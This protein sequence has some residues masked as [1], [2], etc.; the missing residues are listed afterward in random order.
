[1]WDEDEYDWDNDGYDWSMIEDM[2]G[3]E[4]TDDDKQNL[5]DLVQGVIDM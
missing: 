5:D 3:A 4:L 2:T 1:M